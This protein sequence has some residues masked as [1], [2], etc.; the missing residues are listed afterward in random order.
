MS[1]LAIDLVPNKKI[2]FASDFHLGFSGFSTTHEI[3][4]EKKIVRWLNSIAPDAQAIFLVGDIF[5]FWFEYKHAIPKGHI[6]FMGKIAELVD[7]GIKLYFFTGNH[8]LWMFD[9]FQKELHLTVF[10]SP[11]GLHIN[12]RKLL[13]GHGDGLGPGDSFY[14]I[15]KRIFTSKMAQWLFRWIHPDLG[16]GMAKRWSKSSRLQKKESDEIFFGEKE[17]LIQYCR[18]MEKKS[19]YDIYIFG[20]RHLALDIEIGPNSRYYNLGE[21]VNK[22]SYGSFDGEAFELKIYNEN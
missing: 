5:D 2:Y 10:T 22:C 16:I 21:W 17:F 13:V 19:H 20:H 1:D 12:G 9:Y 11:I 18:E 4:R 14:K 15:L 3:E 7:S 8:D 6:R